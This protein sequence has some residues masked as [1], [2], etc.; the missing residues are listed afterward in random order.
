[1]D[2]VITGGEVITAGS[3][4]RAD[5]GVA[6]GRIVQIGGAVPAGPSTRVIDATG[7]F[8]I[9]GGVDVHVHLSP[10]YIPAGVG[11]GGVTPTGG[12]AAADEVLAWADDF[13]SGCERFVG[14]VADFD[15][16]LNALCAPVAVILWVPVALNTL[17]LPDALSDGVPKLSGL[18]I[19]GQP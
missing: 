15:A 11:P 9:P 7:R 1:M 10:A 4:G 16:A 13:V 14:G 5:I 18:V 12:E 3:R 8:V 2:L 6:D 17:W 19:E